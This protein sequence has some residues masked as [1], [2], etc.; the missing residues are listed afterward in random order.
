MD[1]ISSVKDWWFMP[2]GGLESVEKGGASTFA[3]M[4]QDQVVGQDNFS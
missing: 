3:S 1:A 2:L 4:V